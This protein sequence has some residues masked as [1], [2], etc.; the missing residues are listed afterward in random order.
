MACL[1]MGGQDTERPIR[2]LQD[3]TSRQV[4]TCLITLAFGKRVVWCGRLEEGRIKAEA[5]MLYVP[6]TRFGLVAARR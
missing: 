4:S 6:I 1:E 5:A 2:R 3:A